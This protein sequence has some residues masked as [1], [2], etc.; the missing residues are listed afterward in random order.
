MEKKTRWDVR[1]VAE[2]EAIL[3]AQAGSHLSA[4]EFCR[5]RDINYKQFLYVRGKIH[6]KAGQSLVIA[7]PSGFHPVARPRGFIPV[8]VVGSGSSVRV[9]FPRGIELTSD[10]L[11]PAAWVAEVAQ[12]L[13]DKGDEP[14]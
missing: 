12:R 3:K 6:K 14:C 10:D 2:W 1:P 9:R 5:E 11:P 13:V 8:S 4:V 7:R